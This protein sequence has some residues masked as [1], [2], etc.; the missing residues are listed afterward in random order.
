METTE[1]ITVDMV[2]WQS[3]EV[4]L[5]NL[6]PLLALQS[7]TPV[8]Q[9][10]DVHDYNAHHF[11]AFDEHKTPIATCRLTENGDISKPQTTAEWMHKSIENKLIESVIRYA[12][13][14]TKL[15]KLTIVED[16][17]IAPFYVHFGFKEEGEPIIERDLPSQKMVYNINREEPKKASTVYLDFT[18]KKSSTS[19]QNT[20]ADNNTEAFH[21]QT[22]NDLSSY[23][24]AL[25]GVA[26]ST[27]RILKIYSP[28]L[29]PQLFGNHQLIEILSNH[30]RRSRYTEIQVLVMSEKSLITGT[31]GLRSLYEKLPSSIAI[32]KFIPADDE[33]DY[34]EYMISDNGQ[35]SIRGRDRTI[36]GSVTTN[37]S[38]IAKEMNLFDDFWL[39][40]RSIPDLRLTT[41]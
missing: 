41:Y 38:E 9:A 39:K 27:S 21:G 14:H 37:R 26:S 1:N 29:H 17:R 19:T 10:F 30:C 40:S 24:E 7:H 20:E 6:K 28:I 36:N 32:R 12:K 25:K 22:F 33:I 13:E 2:S 15:T 8:S 16:I 34:R 23:L 11:I 3:G 4:I 18:A 31:H 35:M 5:R